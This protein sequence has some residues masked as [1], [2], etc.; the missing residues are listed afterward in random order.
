MRFL[1]ILLISFFLF[2][3]LEAESVQVVTFPYPPLQGASDVS[4]LGVDLELVDAAFGASGIDAEFS[5]VPTKRAIDMIEKG[6][7]PVMIGLLIYFPVEIRSSLA[8]IPL[9]QIDFD[10]FYLKSRFPDGFAFRDIDDLRGYS[11]GVLLGGSTDIFGKENGLA[12][13]G[14]VTLDLV[15]RKLRAG[16]T[17][18]CVANDLAGM[19]EIRR[20]FPG[21]EDL[22]AY[23]PD[24][25]YL[26][27]TA[28]AI[29]DRRNPRC[30][31]LEA[32]FR[33]GLKEIILNG[34]WEAI[35]SRYYAP[36]SI[37]PHCLAKARE[38]AAGL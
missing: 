25:P 20:I 8:I 26:T 28:S 31:E 11:V 16:R 4:E 29:F 9:F 1:F 2:A 6:V 17:D 3:S 14:A 36:L 37:P 21:E 24:P 13:D 12:V 35:V 7:A 32:A 34:T 19:F 18:L 10:I 38:Y 23:C 33:A 30:A 5:L 27:Q 22:F 15:F